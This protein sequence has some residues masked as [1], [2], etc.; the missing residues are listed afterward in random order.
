MIYFVICSDP[1]N[2]FYSGKRRKLVAEIPDNFS[3]AG[4]EN[5]E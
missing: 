2:S 4:K 1:A 5:K 3:S